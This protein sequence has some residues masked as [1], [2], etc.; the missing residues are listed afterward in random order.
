M[1]PP[2]RDPRAPRSF[3]LAHGTN[4]LRGE[5]ILWPI[6]RPTA[7]NPIVEFLLNGFEQLRGQNLSQHAPDDVHVQR[8]VE[9]FTH[10]L[11]QFSQVSTGMQQTF[12]KVLD[13][14]FKALQLPSRKDIVALDQRLQRLEDKIDM[15]LPI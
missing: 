1:L 8:R 14:Y 4:D 2:A 12:E 10:A 7:P 15:L 3:K 11:Q 9:Q 13:A 6:A 5:K